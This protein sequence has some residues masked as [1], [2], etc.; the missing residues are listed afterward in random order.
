MIKKTTVNSI[1][2]KHANGEK[3]T[4]LTAYDYST[5]QCLDDA[6][7]DLILVG[8]S[9]ANV[10]LGYDSTQRI[11]MEEML[12][13]VGAVA[14]GAKRALVIA[15]MPF[16][17]FNVSIE[18]AMK[19]IGRMIK[20]GAHAVKLEGCSD[21]IIEL[22]KRCTQ[23][24][25]PVM[26]HLGFTPQYIHMLGGHKIQGK[27]VEKTLEIVECAK[28]LEQAGAFSVVL[29]MVPKE[30]AEYITKHIN[31]PT[32]GIGAGVNCSGQVVVIDDLL[33]KFSDYVPSFVRKYADLKSTIIDAVKKYCSDVE[34]SLFPS[35]N[36]SF[37]LKEDEKEKLNKEAIKC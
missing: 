24:G 33:G 11:S 8:D 17:S 37:S 29:E 16:M 7:V 23:S 9:A 10:V 31:I 1:L 34:N 15:D 32:I 26:A 5:A 3:I 27:N 28:K 4:V 20:A 6:G 12:V 30:S 25:I 13:F 2:K 35:D 19:N 36:E 21:Y 18:D 14:R 22:T